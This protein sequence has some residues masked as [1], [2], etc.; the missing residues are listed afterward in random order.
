MWFFGNKVGSAIT[1]VFGF[2]HEFHKSKPHKINT[3]PPVESLN[4]GLIPCSKCGHDL[5]LES[6]KPLSIDKCPECETPLFIPMLIKDYW[7][8][9][10]L[11]GGGMGSVYHAFHKDNMQFEVAVKLL[12]RA[13]NKDPYLIEALMG[14]AKI[15]WQL[16][17][18]Q[19]LNKV[20]DFGR[21]HNE[22]YA[23]F[24]FIE[25]TRLDQI[26]ES[27]VKRPNKQVILWA[28][29][30]LSA[31]QHMYDKGFLF[32]D[33]KPQNIMIDKSG[34]V[35]LFDFGLALP[36]DKALNDDSDKIEG[37][38]YYIPP[39]RIVGV[40][41]SQYSEIYSLGMVIFH[42]LAGEPYYSA[43]DIRSLVGKH[44]LSMRL[45]DVGQRLP[46]KTNPHLIEIL[47]KM[48][49]RLPENRYATYMEVAADLFKVYKNDG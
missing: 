41:E 22:Y 35:K 12:P 10:P 19:H 45:S 27:P 24:E 44:V 2:T 16:G 13:R 31:E 4:S 5:S 6:Y 29:Q 9:E 47:N 15:C 25:G 18:H 48:I 26:I 1:D 49:E 34:N 28:L 21:Y 40:G 17:E 33:L 39:E 32:R 36:I 20:I 38:P 11:G 46:P 3:N 7:L 42:I 43:E 23:V 8:Y 14:E 37:S 30:I